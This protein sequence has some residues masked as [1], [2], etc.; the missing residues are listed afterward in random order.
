MAFSLQPRGPFS[1]AAAATFAEG[2]PASDARRDSGEMAFAFALEGDWRTVAVRLEERDGAVRGEVSGGPEDRVRDAVEAIL[3]LDVDGAGWAAVGERDPIVAAAQARLP[4]L[5]PVLFWS[6]YE[7]AAWTIIGQRIRM[8]Q[9][10]AIKQRLAEELG[11][12]VA[13]DG[14]RLPAFPA[15]DRLAALPAGVR[16][17]TGR[18]EEQL[19]A[20]GAAA[21]TGRLDRMRLRALGRDAAEE[22]LRELPGIGPFSAELVWI[23]GVGDPDAL[24]GN[25]RRLAAI[26]RER[27]GEVRM[28]DVAEAWRPFRSWVALLLRAT[29]AG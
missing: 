15:P 21:G 11:E 12:T 28:E 17:L 24:P 9:A 2:F 4:G 14:L 19:R 27:Y 23:R 20:L 3:S 10:A 8:S 25:E 13:L 6:P 26:V 16:G 5:R 1:L 18:K 7:A 29:G 22:D